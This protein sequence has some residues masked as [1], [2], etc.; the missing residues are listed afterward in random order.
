VAVDAAGNLYIA[1]HSN[2]R[3]RM[4][5]PSG[6]ISTIAGN[7]KFGYTGDGGPATS[8][9]LN[10]PDDI[11]VDAKGNVYV[12]D[13]Q[14]QVVRLLTPPAQ[15]A[16]SPPAISAGGVVSAAA[17]GGFTSIAPGSW[18]EIYGSNLAADTR[19]WATTDF[20]GNIAPTSLD[21][22]SVTVGG[23]QAYV[24]YISPGQVNVQVPSNVV[25]GQ[26]QI[27]VT[28]AV[29]ASAA[30]TITV[31]ATEPGMLAPPSFVIGGKQYVVAQFT[32][33]AT[34]V[35]PVNAIPGVPSR[36]AKPGDTMIIYGIGFGPV[37]GVTAGQI[38]PA[39]SAVAIPPQIF[40][41]TSLASLSYA[42]LTPGSV[43]LYQFNVVV[44]NVGTSAAVPLTFTLSGVNGTQTLYT[45]VGN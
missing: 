2:S 6:T 3:I 33:F 19:G 41:G 13:Y 22:T 37:G 18:I 32:D 10:F 26:Q 28:T 16:G 36:P 12:A 23:Q 30:Y 24:D 40:F 38:A 17:F 8:A 5:S 31:N 35:L 39:S 29:G 15:P 43:G 1:D 14:N 7:G 20:N 4:V 34:Y 25:T 11:A 45:A 27:V 44:P 9:A 21:R 42:G